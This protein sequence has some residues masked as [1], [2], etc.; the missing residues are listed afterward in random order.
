VSADRFQVVD[1]GAALVGVVDEQAVVV[2][3]PGPRGLKGDTGDPGVK[4]DKGDQGLKGDQGDKG[5]PGDAGVKGD[6]GD[7]GPPGTAYPTVATVAQL[8]AA[9]ANAGRA[10][11]VTDT[12]TIY[13]S[14]GASWR[15][16]YGDTLARN[17]VTLL[18]PG[19]KPHTSNGYL[20]LRRSGHFVYLA[21]RL[22]RVTAGTPYSGHTAV[23]AMPMGF[24]PSMSY[25]VQGNAN[26]YTKFVGLAT[27]LSVTSRI[28]VRF[29]GAAGNYVVDDALN[30]S[31]VWMTEQ[32][33]PAVLPG[34]DTAEESPTPL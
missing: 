12:S 18:D 2:T 10:Y 31:A 14:D 19:W 6:P 29:D 23:I 26:I 34:S 11:W 33:W 25:N 17:V 22:Q 27:N 1:A 21:G 5:D 30:L 24:Y 28:D 3:V 8:P 4:G 15:L 20:R 16:V 9:A 13:T 32:A 7:P